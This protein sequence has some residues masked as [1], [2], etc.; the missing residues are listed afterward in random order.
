[1]R[2]KLY[3]TEIAASMRELFAKI[4]IFF[5]ALARYQ[6]RCRV[7]FRSSPLI[8]IAS[9]SGRIVTLWLPAASGQRK[10]AF[11]QAL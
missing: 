5:Y 9:S 4:R 8:S 11:L 1:M 10:A 6:F 2:G 3:F 7:C